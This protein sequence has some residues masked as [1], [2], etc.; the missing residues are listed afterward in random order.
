MSVTSPARN[1]SRAVV[2]RLMERDLGSSRYETIDRIS[3]QMIDVARNNPARRLIVDLSSVAYF[4]AA[5]L[6]VLVR[7][8]NHVRQLGKQLVVCGDRLGL[9]S[10]SQ[11]DL[12]FPVKEDVSQALG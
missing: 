9:L 5:F 4:G 10:L 7:L 6:G 1:P 12:L 8:A 3:E 11:L 2:I